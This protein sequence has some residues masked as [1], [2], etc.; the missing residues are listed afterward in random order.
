MDEVIKEYAVGV[1][2][3]FYGN[4]VLAKEFLFNS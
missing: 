2:C 1:F 4:N 3:E